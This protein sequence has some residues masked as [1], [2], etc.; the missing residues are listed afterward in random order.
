MTDRLALW[1]L[2][3]LFALVLALAGWG[4]AAITHALD[5]QDQRATAI[6]TQLAAEQIMM[7]HRIT[8]LESVQR[9]LLLRLPTSGRGS[10]NDKTSEDYLP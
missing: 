7:E 1:L 4:V 6:A 3:A 9:L 8:T 5:Q 10:G 2:G